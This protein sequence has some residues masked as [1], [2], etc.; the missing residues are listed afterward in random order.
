MPLQPHELNFQDFISFLFSSFR[1][2]NFHLSLRFLP[3]PTL[4]AYILAS[5]LRFLPTSA[6]SHRVESKHHRWCGFWLYVT[7]ANMQKMPF[8]YLSPRLKC[9]RIVGKC[10]LL[11]ILSSF[12]KEEEKV[13]NVGR[14]KMANITE[15]SR[16][17]RIE[18]IAIGS[19]S[20]WTTKFYMQN[21]EREW[22]WWWEDAFSS[23]E[24]HSVS[25]TIEFR[26]QTEL[27]YSL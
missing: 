19:G 16:M 2:P 7:V 9:G 10:H 8:S 4:F 11:E 24:I 13:F 23:P 3:F 21:R 17:Q 15:K 27:V 22:W 12:N 18:P 6:L 1:F 5:S 14:V 20:E 26:Q 25:R